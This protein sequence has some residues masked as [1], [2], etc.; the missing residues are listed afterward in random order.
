M[1]SGGVGGYFGARLARGGHETAFVAR[2]IHLDAI[3]ADGLRV[4]EVDDC[5]TLEVNATDTSAEI[6]PVDFVLFSVKLWDTETA[7]A[8]CKPLI[9]PE[10]AVLSLQNG[11]ES[12][13]IL[14]EILGR[15]CVIGGVA[16]ISSAI[17]EPGLIA[18]A[19]PFQRIRFGELDGAASERA[20]RLAAALSRSGIEHDQPDDINA[21]IWTKF[22]FLVGLSALTALTRR[23][24]GEVRADTDTRCLLASL[25][26]EAAAVARAVEIPIDADVVER[27]M[28]F[29]DELPPTVRASMALDLESGQRLELPWLSGAVVRIGAEHEVET[30]ANAFVVAGLKLHQDGAG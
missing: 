9:G 15:D 4:R 28:R 18:C 12:E 25:M 20:R 24:I 8:A 2:G 29:I 10:T 21:A 1:G 3:R 7:A 6:G 13:R 27:H 16:E 30:P 14:T 19:S 5:Y 23:P 26:A 22:I 11:V 17:A